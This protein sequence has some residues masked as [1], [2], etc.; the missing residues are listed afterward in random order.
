MPVPVTQN[1]IL[2]VEDPSGSTITVTEKIQDWTKYL[3]ISFRGPCIPYRLDDDP[4]HY[5]SSSVR[6]KSSAEL[7][8]FLDNLLDPELFTKFIAIQSGEN[9]TDLSK[10]IELEP[11]LAYV[12]YLGVVNDQACISGKS[13][14][15]NFRRVKLDAPA[16][17]FNQLYESMRE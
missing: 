10:S 13:T 2:A 4:D 9:T 15:Y 17:T 12:G 5:Y 11:N 16:D 1:V 7:L 6:I 3:T 14:G 8:S